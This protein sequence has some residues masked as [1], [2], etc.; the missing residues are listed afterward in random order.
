M[1]LPSFTGASFFGLDE[2]HLIARGIGRH[3]WELINVANTKNTI[4]FYT[5][6]N[7]TQSADV[8]PFFISKP[9]LKRIGECITQARKT[10]PVSFQGSFYNVL[11]KTEG[12]RAVDWLDFLLYIVPTLVVPYLPT[13]GSKKATLSLIKGC[14][15]SL[16]WNISTLQIEEIKT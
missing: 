1:G 6:P 7:G 2:L 3:F 4:S 13:V 15:L 14:A 10:I 11:E 8:Y 12:T 9:N 5:K 16:Q